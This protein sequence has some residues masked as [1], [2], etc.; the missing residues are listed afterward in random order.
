VFG[1]GS[2]QYDFIHVRDVAQANVLAMQ[3]DVSGRCYNVGRGIG[4]TIRELTELLQRLSG[5]TLPI[6]YEPAGQTFVTNRIGSTGAAQRDLG[7][8]WQIDLEEGMR[9]LIDWRRNH[10]EALL[11]RQDRGHGAK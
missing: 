7:F 2:Q 6:R 3:S 9:S 5:S 1:D 8:R 4:T 10:R 11:A